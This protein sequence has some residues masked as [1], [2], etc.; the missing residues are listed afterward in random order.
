MNGFLKIRKW[1]ALFACV[2]LLGI[3]GCQS[4][5]SAQNAGKADYTVLAP[6]EY[7]ERIRQEIEKK[8]REVFQ[9]AYTDQGYLYLAVGY[10]TQKTT[11][12]SI[13]VSYVTHKQDD[14][15]IKTV[16]KG[17]AKTDAPVKA[18]TWPVI[19]LKLPDSGGTVYFEL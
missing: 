19:V 8:K 2:C 11:C 9:L 1:I 15:Y 6:E 13:A 14:I 16:L 7:P 12:Y 10:G 3:T 5:F 18:E 4:N 17:P